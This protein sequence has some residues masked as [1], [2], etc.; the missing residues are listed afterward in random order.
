MRRSPESGEKRGKGVASMEDRVGAKMGCKD[1]QLLKKSPSIKG[2]S[3]PTLGKSG[4]QDQKCTTG[5]M[6][7]SEADV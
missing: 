7:P 6:V 3:P 4:A 2:I 5:Q 1:T